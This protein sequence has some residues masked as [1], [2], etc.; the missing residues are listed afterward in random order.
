MTTSH[1]VDLAIIGA[2]PAGLYAAYY[3]GFRGLSMVVID[4]LPERSTVPTTVAGGQEIRL[5][6]HQAV[7]LVSSSAQRATALTRSVSES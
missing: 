6:G 3:A 4:S 1:D 7:V 2:G 5:L